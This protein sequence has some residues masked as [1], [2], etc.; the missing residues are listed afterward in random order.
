MSKSRHHHY[1]SQCY[2]KGFTQGSAKKSKLTVID[3]KGKKEFETTPRNVG[4]M[5]DFNR[6]EIEGIDPEV[7]EKAQSDFEGKVATAIKKVGET[8]QFS[9]ENKSLI[10]DLIGMLAIKSPEMREHLAKPQIDIAKKILAMGLESKE[11]WES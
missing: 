11:R 9:G 2:L 6:V 3:L 4:G 10:L 8:F 1:L 5:R 7:V